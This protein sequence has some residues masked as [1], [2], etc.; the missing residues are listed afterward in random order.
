ML[1]TRPATRASLSGFEFFS[2]PPD[3]AFPRFRLLGVLYPTNKLVSREWRNILPGFLSLC[4]RDNL[5][6]QIVWQFVYHTIGKFYESHTSITPTT[7]LIIP[8]ATGRR[9]KKML[10]ADFSRVRSSEKLNE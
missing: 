10:Q 9:G 3:P 1:A 6:S 2:G 7:D 5:I 4:S 8:V